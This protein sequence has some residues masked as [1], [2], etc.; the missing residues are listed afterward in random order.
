M[1]INIGE[2]L[3]NLWNQSGFANLSAGLASGGWQN[4]VMI[5]I[6][7]V[8]LYLAIVKK[9]EPLLLC[10]I[11]F[12]CILTNLP[13]ANLYHQGLWSCYVEG[14]PYQVIE[15]GEVV[16]T[17]TQEQIDYIH[18]DAELYLKLASEYL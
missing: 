13:G 12:G 17:L 10:G 18:A 2:I 4:L 5:L 16:K 1:Q 3:L 15:G 8:L 14:I 6:G 11:A 7:C 9:F